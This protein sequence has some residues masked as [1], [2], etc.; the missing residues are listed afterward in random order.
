MKKKV[1]SL[2]TVGVMLVALLAGCAT[3]T[4]TTTAATTAAAA[5]TTAAAATTAA[6]ATTAAAATT[7]GSGKIWNVAVCNADIST[8]VFAFMEKMFASH[9]A[10][11]NMKVTQFD[12]KGDTA[13]QVQQVESA[14]AQGFDAIILDPVDP[15]G[16]APACKKAIAAGIPIATF[17][18]D[19]PAAN[20]AD[21]TFCVTADDYQAGVIAGEAF[22]K[23]FPDGATIVEVG[24]MA[25]YDAAIKRH[26]GFRKTIEGSNIK[27]LDYQT[28]TAWDANQAMN[29]MQDFI[30]KYGDQIQGV[31]CHWDGGLTGCVTAMTAAKIDA[32]KIFSVAVDGN[33]DG[34]KNVTE[35]VQALSIM[36][37]FDKMTNICEQNLVKVLNGEKVDST[38]MPAWDFVTKDTISTLTAPEW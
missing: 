24:G 38:T 13:T 6:G 32:T 25:G 11:N 27:V 20:E 33:K 1:I 10:E 19:L 21:R 5:T 12:G 9:A 31:Y 28:C 4:S 37:N 17:S 29:I 2:I 18:S 7:A 26:D 14:I 35:G 15:N 22:M 34:F 30:V 23:Q 8:P 3:G 36:Q 16:L